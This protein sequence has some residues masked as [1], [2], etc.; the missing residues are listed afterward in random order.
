M[1]SCSYVLKLD[2]QIRLLYMGL[3][4]KTV[5]NLQLVLNAVARLIVGTRRFEHIRPILARLHWLPICFQAQ[6]KVLVGLGP[7]Y[8]M[9]HLFRHEPTRT[10]RST[11]KALLRLPTP[12]E[13]QR[14]AT[15]E[16]AFSVVAPRLWNDLPKE[17]RLAPTLLSFR[18]QVKTYLFS[19][20]VN[21]SY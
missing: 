11:S 17:A 13:A 7:Q 15:R 1:F 19:Q 21:N 2:L 9:E 10:L 20:A 12:R 16:R 8:L 14:K 3:P 5:R 6:F 4:L 18:R